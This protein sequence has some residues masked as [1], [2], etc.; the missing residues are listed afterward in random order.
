M[1]EGKHPVYHKKHAKDKAFREIDMALGFDDYG[2][3]THK[4][5]PYKRY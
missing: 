5:L 3:Y 2:K 4:Y 1:W